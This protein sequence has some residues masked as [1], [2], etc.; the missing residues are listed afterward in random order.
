MGEH[1][2]IWASDRPAPIAHALLALLT[3]WPL[4]PI[5]F[6]HL[7]ANVNIVIIASLTV[8]TGCW[9]SI[10]LLPPTE[11]MTKKDAMRFPF[12]GSAVLFSLFLAFKFLPKDV[13]NTLFS[14]YIGTAAV[15]AL[16]DTVTPYVSPFFPLDLQKLELSLPPFKI[17][18]VI[19]ASKE[20]V[21]FTAP[22]LVIVTLSALFCVWYLLTRN[23]LANNFLGLAFSLEGIEHLSLGSVQVGGILL[24]GLFFY[25]IFWV[26]CTPVMVSVAK[27]FD[28][29]IKLLFPRGLS[30]ADLAAGSSQQFSLLGLGDIVIPGIFVALML[31]YDVA[32]GFKSS[33]F[34][35]SFWGYVLGLGTT[36]V[37]MNVFKAAQPALLYIVPCVL[38][39]LAVHA[40]VN[41][42]LGKVFSFH[43]E[44][45]PKAE[46][47]GELEPASCQAG[48]DKKAK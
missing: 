31:R 4:T 38:G 20:R 13:V 5:R 42:E 39:C 30:A 25:D 23:W 14:L 36:I 15:M 7:P 18:Y 44:V 37:V 43:E 32:H 35:S 29:P 16:T 28:A 11:T 2:K 17:P 26:F 12:I 27:N 19:D 47:A 1:S 40:A 3:I 9:R 48:G 8:Y 33:Y 22:Q 41:G 45:A 10:K 46:Q 21:T 34:Q 6:L 24:V